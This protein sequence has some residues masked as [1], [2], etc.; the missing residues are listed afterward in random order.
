MG[1]TKKLDL[2]LDAFEERFLPGLPIRRFKTTHFRKESLYLQSGV[3]DYFEAILPAGQLSE[4]LSSQL[5]VKPAIRMIG[6][7]R[8][9]P[10]AEIS[11]DIPYSKF[12]FEGVVDIQ[13]V[14]RWFEAGYTVNLRGVHLFDRRLSRASSIL[15]SIFGCYVRANIYITPEG[16]TGLVPHYDVHDV[17]VVHISGRKSWTI[18]E[19]SF[20][21][22]TPRHE[23]SPG[24]YD[25]GQAKDELVLSPG[26]I[27][28]L[29]RGVPHSARTLSEGGSSVHITFG[30]EE[31]SLADVLRV[32]S[33]HLEDDPYFRQS[34]AIHGAADERSYLDG[35]FERISRRI[36]TLSDSEKSKL[37]A[38][39]QALNTGRYPNRETGFL[40]G[41]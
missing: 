23:F 25:V 29:P 30:V 20:D 21:N 33:D 15:S 40:Q 34:L 19:N 32:L 35:V 1:N 14:K 26:D 7:G 6:E 31:P 37:A 10:L 28:Y 38:R 13:K 9:L 5:L 36:Q 2:E 16:M 18:Y 3:A 17:F 41:H 4:I 39:V 8:V 11:M 12:A 27:L 24:S 22:P